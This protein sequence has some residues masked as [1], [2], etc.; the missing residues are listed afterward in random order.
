MM[1]VSET[2]KCLKLLTVACH[3]YAH[4]YTDIQENG[5]RFSPV[6]FFPELLPHK[7]LLLLSHVDY[8]LSCPEIF[9]SLHIS[10][11]I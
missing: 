10:G 6:Y 8:G 7:A 11:T 9:P 1:T 5:A 2:I 4:T 3:L